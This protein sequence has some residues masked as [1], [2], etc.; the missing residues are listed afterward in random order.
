M[1][2]RSRSFGA[3]V[4]A[5]KTSTTLI[6][7]FA[8]SDL[9]S[10]S[11]A[12]PGSCTSTLCCCCTSAPCCCS[13][14]CCARGQHPGAARRR[15][16]AARPSPAGPVLPFVPEVAHLGGSLRSRAQRDTAT[17]RLGA[18]VNEAS[19]H[20]HRLDDTKPVRLPFSLARSGAFWTKRGSRRPHPS[21]Q[22]QAPHAQAASGRRASGGFCFSFL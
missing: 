4:A 5:E 10:G 2:T 19:L 7:E 14:K 13:S 18:L 1:R 22:R 3:F 8:V 17:R 20:R 6:S 21:G 16:A 11:R 9:K 15:R 12:A